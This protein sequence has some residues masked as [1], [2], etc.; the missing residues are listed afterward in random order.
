MPVQ[1]SSILDEAKETRKSATVFDVSH[2]GRVFVEGKDAERFVDYLT[3]NNVRKLKEGDVQYSL[4]LNEKGGT[5]DDITVYKLGDNRFMLCINAANREKDLNHMKNLAKDFD[6]QIEDKSDEL[7]QLAVQGPKAVEVVEK[8][9]PAVG[10]LGFYKFKTF[11]DTIVSRTGYT[12]EDGFEIYIPVEEGVELYKKLVGEI[13]PAGLGAR[14]VLR[15]EAGYPLYGHE[16]NEDLDPREANLSRFIDL[17]K[18]FY[19]KE[20]LLKRGEPKRKLHGLVLSKRLIGRQGDKVYKGETQI[21]VISSGTFSPNLGKS[22]ALAFLERE[23]KLGETVEV[24][25]RGK[26]IPAEVV[27]SRF[28]DNTPRRK[29]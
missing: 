16:L 24:E 18:N 20:G 26:K 12:G 10:G 25:I 11:G 19:G 27:K 29:K 17:E 1:F 6:V 5:V 15:I 7:I 22:I 21:G 8:Y 3:T 28:I 23:V 14:D 2:M 9:F 4:M 13:K